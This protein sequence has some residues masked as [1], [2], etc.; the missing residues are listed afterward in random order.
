MLR[1]L[2]VGLLSTL[3]L[4][5]CPSPY[6]N[7]ASL[8]NRALRTGEG[9]VAV[10]VVSNAERLSQWNEQW[11]DV[12][13]V[14]VDNMALKKE[15]ARKAWEA[16]KKQGKK[17]AGPD[18]ELDVYVLEADMSL[19]DK[20][21]VFV[22][23][24]PEGEYMVTRLFS[25]F[26]NGNIVSQ[27]SMPV[28]PSA[29]V[30]PVRSGQFTNLGTL[31]FQPIANIENDSFWDKLMGRN[32]VQ[33]KAIVARSADQEDLAGFL[34]TRFPQIKDSVDLMKA[35]A[36]RADALDDF[37][38]NVSDLLKEAALPTRYQRLGFHPFIAVPSRLGI[39]RWMDGQ[40][41]VTWTRLP[42][43]SQIMTV[44]DWRD[45]IVAGGERGTVFW[46]HAIAGPWHA[47][48]PV[49]VSHVVEQIVMKEDG[50]G[51]ALVVGPE[52]HLSVYRLAHVSKPWELLHSFVIPRGIFGVAGGRFLLSR[53]DG[54][55]LWL[56]DKR[57]SYDENS[58]QWTQKKASGFVSL[59]RMGPGILTGVESSSWDGVGST[60]VSVDDGAHWESISRILNRD[61]PDSMIEKQPAVVDI[62]GKAI[63]VGRE[64][65]R[66]PKDKRPLA[67]LRIIRGPY[68]KGGDFWTHHGIVDEDCAKLLSAIS[69]AAR[70][71]FQCDDGSVRVTTDLGSTWT[72]I[73]LSRLEQ[74]RKVYE[75]MEEKARMMRDKEKRQQDKPAA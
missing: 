16:R 7:Q 17:A 72:T 37:R 5:A 22:G 23:A 33:I 69:S 15:E 51:Y 28:G 56:D 3:F 31:V 21:R 45:G 47:M 50:H 20:S 44:A 48:Q 9:V 29:G 60:V 35:N 24:V 6:V 2:L 39:V 67:P 19:P 58:G 43:R 68:D 25:Y 70:L 49:P 30:F 46:S 65:R 27:L 14:R 12:V 54:V 73:P 62:E 63:S 53:D 52:R 66:S 59:Y 61:M 71:Y 40:E 36:W 11:T 75:G 8:D 4:T 57:W 10:Q 74:I 32:Q 41:Q 1:L 34:S 18:V 42:T 55:E 38:A 64:Y 26:S 13:V